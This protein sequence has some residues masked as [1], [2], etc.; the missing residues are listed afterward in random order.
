M[1]DRQD[2]NQ[3]P[4][5]AG[6]AQIEFVSSTGSSV[7]LPKQR[8]ASKTSSAMWVPLKASSSAMVRLAQMVLPSGWTLLAAAI[9]LAWRVLTVVARGQSAALGGPELVVGVLGDIGLAHA[10]ASLARSM[11]LTTG[12]AVSPTADVVRSST[13]MLALVWVVMTLFRLADLV[14]GAVDKKPIDAS[15]YLAMLQHPAAFATSGA[16]WAAIA[17][18]VVTAFLVRYCL[19]CDM[20]TAQALSEAE[21]RGRFVTMTLCALGLGVALAG[22]SAVRGSGYPAASVAQMPEV[23]GMRSLAAALHDPALRKS[24]D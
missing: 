17:V 23:V 12:K 16:T 8:A 19:T 21:P 18:A 6:G 20:E 5:P 2:S 13:L 10:V 7:K 11:A 22:A 4:D 24:E 14:I 9:L 15:F 3:P 1:S